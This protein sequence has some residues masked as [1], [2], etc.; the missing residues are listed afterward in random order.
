MKKPKPIMGRPRVGQAISITLEPEQL[1][2]ID[3]SR[4]KDFSRAAFV[5]KV[6]REAMKS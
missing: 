3:A 2:W 1:A 6:L 4:G 5:R